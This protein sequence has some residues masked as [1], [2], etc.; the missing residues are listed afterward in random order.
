M[1]YEGL[2]VQDI[3]CITW[4]MGENPLIDRFLSRSSQLI[5]TLILVEGVMPLVKEE[6]Y[7][8]L[9][10]YAAGRCSV[11]VMWDKLIVLLRVCMEWEMRSTRAARSWHCRCCFKTQETHELKFLKKPALKPALTPAGFPEQLQKLLIGSYEHQL[12]AVNTGT[13]HR[14]GTR[15]L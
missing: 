8:T 6:R 3:W 9:C 2:S 14:R 13:M 10:S 5:W 4:T 1:K 12:M 11:C 7:L 15:A